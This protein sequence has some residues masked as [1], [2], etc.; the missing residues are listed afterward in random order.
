MAPLRG[1]IPNRAYGSIARDSSYAARCLHDAG[2]RS[3]AIAIGRVPYI[4]PDSSGFT[5]DG[6]FAFAP[7]HMVTGRPEPMVASLAL[8]AAATSGVHRPPTWVRRPAIERAGL[9]V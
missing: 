8:Y 4:G 5:A 2:R 7:P 9:L 3:C 1:R 6:A